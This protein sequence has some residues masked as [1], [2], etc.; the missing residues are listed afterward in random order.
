[1]SSN[2][3]DIVLAVNAGSGSLSIDAFTVG[4][5]D[6]GANDFAASPIWSLRF[7]RYSTP[8]RVEIHGNGTNAEFAIDEAVEDGPGTALH[9]GLDRLWQGDTA[10]I[11]IAE[12]IVAVGHRIVHGG[13]HADR[14]AL[15]DG[16]AMDAA[17]D[18]CRYAPLHNPPALALLD[19]MRR[20][21]P[22][23][24]H[25]LCFDTAFHAT[26]PEAARLYAGPATWSD[27][28]LRRYGFHGL[29]HER[30]T[31][32]TARLLG[33]PPVDTSL[34]SVHFGGGCSAAAVRGGVC[35]D[36]SMGLTPNEGFAMA[37][38]SGS[39]DPGLLPRPG[40][41]TSRRRTVPCAC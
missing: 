14:H 32:R 29:A 20:A 13:A 28:G 17:R 27:R 23:A 11:D 37:E 18:A 41:P 10:V 39:V 26:L 33:K 6:A 15:A 36:T 7:T 31:R 38:R 4:A 30:A 25:A 40:I 5:V 8:R 24:S 1:M 12:R 34:V 16:R 3:R 21:L 35:V 19:H 22:G 9:L 2:A